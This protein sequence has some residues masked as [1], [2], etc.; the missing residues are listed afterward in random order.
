MGCLIA[1]GSMIWLWPQWQSG[2]LR[3]N[4]HDALETYQSALQL[5]LGNEQDAVKL[6]YQRMEVN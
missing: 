5:L 2:P 4:A 3:R 1:F 6:A